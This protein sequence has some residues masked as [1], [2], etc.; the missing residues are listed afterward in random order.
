MGLKVS[1]LPSLKL[2][3][4]ACNNKKLSYNTFFLGGGGEEGRNFSI[5]LALF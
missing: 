5:A 4:L 2:Y 3:A 1:T